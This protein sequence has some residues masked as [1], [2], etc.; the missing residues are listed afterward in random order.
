M[1]RCDNYDETNYNG[2]E[3]PCCVHILRDMARTFDETMCGLGLEYV[4]TFG[5]LLGL[6]R[7]DRMIPWTSDIDYIIPSKHVANAMVDLWDTN[8]TALTGAPLPFGHQPALRHG[9][10]CGGQAEGK[11]GRKTSFVK[12]D[13]QRRRPIHGFL[14]RSEDAQMC[15]RSRERMCTTVP[16]LKTRPPTRSNC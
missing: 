12:V 6:V 13:R 11:V 5:T 1:A 16:L 9:R 14:H 3:P 10:F 7:S 15:S 4:A 2:P 8:A